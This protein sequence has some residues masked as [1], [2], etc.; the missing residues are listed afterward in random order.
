MFS[1]L[2]LLN[3]PNGRWHMFP[4]WHFVFQSFSICHTRFGVYLWANF[5][6]VDEVHALYCNLFSLALVV[7]KIINDNDAIVWKATAAKWC[8]IYHGGVPQI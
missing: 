1:I 5:Q 6:E 8:S 4:L 3:I 7:M 2:E